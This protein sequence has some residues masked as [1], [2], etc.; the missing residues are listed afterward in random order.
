[1][2]SLSNN[3]MFLFHSQS[4][5]AGQVKIFLNSKNVSYNDRVDIY[6]KGDELTNVAFHR[7][8]NLVG[9]C[10]SK[11]QR[12]VPDEFGQNIA[13]N[14]NKENGSFVLSILSITD[15]VCGDYSCLTNGKHE[16][17]TTVSY[18]GI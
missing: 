13:L 16:A 17:K 18:S 1:M 3:L 5:F 2:L 6:C 8:G 10:F 4:V 14:W 15:L 11:Q 7:N 9:S 12:T